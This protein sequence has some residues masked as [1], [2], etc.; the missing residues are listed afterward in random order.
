MVSG[1]EEELFKSKIDPGG[2]CVRVITNSVLC[3][4]CG[5]WVHGRCAKIKKAAGRLATHFVCSKCIG[6]MKGAVVSFEKLCDEVEIANE[7]CYLGD[8]LNAS[9]RCEA[10]VTARVRIGCVRFRECGKLLLGNRFPLRMKRKVNRGCV[11]SA[12]LYGIEIW[13]LPKKSKR[14]F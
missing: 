14:Q 1:S 6:I 4:K 9:S 13:S 3:T 2:V 8:R 11:R 10:E 7:F 5:S 12:I